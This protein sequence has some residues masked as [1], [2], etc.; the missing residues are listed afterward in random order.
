MSLWEITAVYHENHAI[1]EYALNTH[2]SRCSLTINTNSLFHNFGN[3]WKMHFYAVLIFIHGHGHPLKLPCCLQVCS[4]CGTNSIH[5]LVYALI[6]SR[7]HY[8]YKIWGS[9]QYRRVTSCVV[10]FITIWEI[11]S[12]MHSIKILVH[13]ITFLQLPLKKKRQQQQKV[14]WDN[15]CH[16]FISNFCSKQFLRI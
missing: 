11:K 13:F 1:H 5:K 10:V 9:V 4:Y 3:V 8:V 15:M 6:F 12:A 7:L 2:S 14:Y 16:I